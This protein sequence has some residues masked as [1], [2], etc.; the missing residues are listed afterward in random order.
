[1]CFSH[2]NIFPNA[3]ELKAAT[4]LM[5]PM[6]YLLIKNATLPYDL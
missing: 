4:I 5:I 3:H 2:F 1:M 6:K